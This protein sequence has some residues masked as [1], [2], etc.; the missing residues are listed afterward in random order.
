M[1][2]QLPIFIHQRVRFSLIPSQELIA[3]DHDRGG[4]GQLHFPPP[5]KKE[6]ERTN[7]RFE[8][9]KLLFLLFQRLLILVPLLEDDF[10]LFSQR[11]D[12]LPEPLLL[13]RP[14]LPSA[15]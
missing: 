12:A 13:F 8:N 6:Q 5:N 11:T 7:L 15:V 9:H 3:L 1:L 4:K 14:R 10:K 2:P